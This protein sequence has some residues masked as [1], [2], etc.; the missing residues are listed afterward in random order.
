MRCSANRRHPCWPGLRS[1]Q[2]ARQWGGPLRGRSVR[3]GQCVRPSRPQAW[4]NSLRRART[5][6]A[7]LE[8]PRRCT[9][10]GP[11][12]GYRILD[13]SIWQQG[14]YATAMLA[15]MGADVVKIE[16]YENPDPGRGLGAP[17]PQSPRRAY[18]D[19]LNRGKRS[20]TLDLKTD[21]GLEVFWRL[22]GE[23]DVFHNNMRGGTMERL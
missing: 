19:A 8:A 14:T 17:D 22:V 15:D 7:D 13:L 6:D 10:T 23:S 2:R 18:F 20:I 4:Q 1:Y 12:A 16:S 9:V 3:P 21:A 11:L 5:R